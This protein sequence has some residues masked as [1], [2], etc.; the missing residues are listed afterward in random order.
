MVL[1]VCAGALRRYLDGR[2]DLPEKPLVAM[3]PISVRNAEQRGTMGNQV[4][5]MLVSL[6]TELDDPMARLRAVS[7]G[8]RESKMYNQAIGARTLMDTSNIIPF[9]IA[10]LGARLYTRMELASKHRP[11]FNLVIT[12]VPG[13]QMPLYV[14]GAELLA[15]FGAAPVFDGLGLIF[16][17]FSYNGTLSIGATSCPEILPKPEELTR[18]LNPALDDLH[19]AATEDA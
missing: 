11:I 8:A 19:A 14:A 3:V 7:G 17:V 4:S 13:P 1:T 10:G 12:N 2:G 9:S 18:M 16:P 5:A 6:A 15:H